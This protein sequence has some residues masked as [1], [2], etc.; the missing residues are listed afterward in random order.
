MNEKA[1]RTLWSYL[2]SALLVIAV[3]SYVRSTG[4]KLVDASLKIGELD[5]RG[6]PVISIPVIVLLSSVVQR[7]GRDYTLNSLAS[8]PIG[9]WPARIPV[10]FLEPA[11]LDFTTSLGRSYQRWVFFL[12]VLLP[13][14]IELQQ[15]ILFLAGNVSI[16]D[17]F[18]NSLS[19]IHQLVPSGVDGTRWL[20]DYRY[21][22]LQYYPILQPWLY[23]V[24]SLFLIVITIRTLIQVFKTGNPATTDDSSG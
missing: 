19:G 11:D 6:V 8:N 23:V 5:P 20:T 16:D 12:I 9:A 10:A 1:L 7:L 13:V 17:H 21:A 15:F 22:T 24:L 2:G 3:A 14:I 18:V 4:S